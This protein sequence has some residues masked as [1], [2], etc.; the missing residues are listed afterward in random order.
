ENPFDAFGD[1]KVKEVQ[2]LDGYKFIIDED[3]W[4]MIRPSG[5]E[6]V[7]R[8]YGQARDEGRVRELL[9]AVGFELNQLKK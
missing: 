4:T 5:T 6:P 9:D 1:F 2:D 3:T 7:L 8:V